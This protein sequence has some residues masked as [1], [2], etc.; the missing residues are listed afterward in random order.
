MAIKKSKRELIDTGTD[1]RYVKRNPDG[2]FKDS[3]DVSKT[4]LPI[5]CSS[6]LRVIIPVGDPNMTTRYPLHRSDWEI[7]PVYSIDVCSNTT[8]AGCSAD[9]ETVWTAFDQWIVAQ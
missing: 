6:R 3:V 5:R 9:N 4:C 2:T 7:H 1:K 8:L